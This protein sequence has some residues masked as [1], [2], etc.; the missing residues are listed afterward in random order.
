MRFT[1][2]PLT[3]AKFNQWLTSQESQQAK[4][5]SCAPSGTSLSVT[6]D[7]IHFSAG[8]LAAPAGQPFTITFD[9]KDSGVPHNVAIY[10][11]SSASKVLFRGQIVTG[12]TTTTYHVPALPAG[13]Y[14]FRCDVHPT[15]MH[16]TF[17]VK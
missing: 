6:A 12:A 10:S 4:T 15:A 13:T 11:D 3:R 8:C 16:G 1:V 14:Y 2:A 5:S 7:N 17:I 9:N